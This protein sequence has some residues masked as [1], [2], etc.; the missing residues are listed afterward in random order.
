MFAYGM[1]LILDLIPLP[2][3]AVYIQSVPM[4][5]SLM[6]FCSLF[7]YLYYFYLYI[8]RHQQHQQHQRDDFTANRRIGARDRQTN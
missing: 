1:R 8:Y 6:L 2:L 3:L 5:G 7:V 4:T